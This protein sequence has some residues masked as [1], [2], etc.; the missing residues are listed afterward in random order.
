MTKMTKREKFAIVR[1]IVEASEHEMID[2]L[3]EFVDHE[4]ELL[5]RKTS[6]ERKPTAVQVA[7]A[8][9]KDAIMDG[10]EPNRLYT[11]TEFIKEIPGCE[12]LTTQ[13][14][15]ALCGQL[16][17]EGRLSRIKEKG[18]TFFQLA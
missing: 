1:S 5:G 4:V 14:V 8:G 9:I 3:L 10:A 12:E 15:T 11:I 13:K 17:A 6:G 2:V 18:K 16:V 7:N